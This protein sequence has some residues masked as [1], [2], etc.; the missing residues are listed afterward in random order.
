MSDLKKRIESMKNTKQKITELKRPDERTV[1][2]TA[3]GLDEL[4]GELHDLKE[5]KRKQVSEKIQKAREY[6]DLSENSEY[7]AAREEQ[8][9]IEG[10]IVELESMLKNVEII[11][12]TEQHTKVGIGSKVKVEMDGK[13][14]EYV[15]VGKVEADPLKKKISNESPVGA[16]LLG[17][18]VGDVIEIKTP[19]YSYKCK[20]LEIN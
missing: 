14:E 13:R 1:Y 11:E 20:I 3:K 5:V 17:A 9:M 8:A 12:A 4:H 15:I 6:G 16:A 19:A 2:L 10:R 7:D 18:K